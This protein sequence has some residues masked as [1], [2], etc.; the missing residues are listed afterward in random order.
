ML[1]KKKAGIIS[2]IIAILLLIFAGL[3]YVISNPSLD[4]EKVTK[5]DGSQ[6]PSIAEQMQNNNQ[7]IIGITEEKLSNEILQL[8]NK[9][10]VVAIYGS[11]ARGSETSRSDVIMIAKYTPMTNDCVLISVPRDTRVDIPGEKV[12]KINHA[13]AFGGAKLLTQTL[14]NLFNTKID[15]YLIFSFEDFKTIVDKL[16]GV[17][18]DSKKDYGYDET[19]VPKG[20]SILTGEQ[21]LF[22]VRYRHDNEGDFG[23][24]QRQQEVIMSILQK[25]RD[26]NHDDLE[27]HAADIYTKSLETNMDL[28]TLL[29]YYQIF[30]LSPQIKFDTYML[31]TNGKMIDNIYYGIIDND[32]LEIIK[33]HLNQ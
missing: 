16:G 13:Y 21:A 10:I 3:A 32:S 22:Y 17:K 11:D 7:E 9:P 1:N 24:I 31:K 26:T 23:R 2:I 33:N 6:G 4:N 5:I 28:P 25:L 20:A 18:V 15:Y 14:D 19:I 27:Q 8:K 29:N 30:K 12:D